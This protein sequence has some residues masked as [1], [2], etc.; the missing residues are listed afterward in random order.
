MTSAE[1]E[2][3][4][5]AGCR[6]R[7][8]VLGRAVDAPHVLEQADG[9]G[10]RLGQGVRRPARDV[11]DLAADLAADVAGN[12]VVDLVDARQGA[13]RLRRPGPRPGG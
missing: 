9:L 7:G 11:V 3:A 10:H 6:A 5:T 13:D 8:D 4:S 12:E 2:S 1:R